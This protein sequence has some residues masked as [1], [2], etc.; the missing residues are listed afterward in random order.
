MALLVPLVSAPSQWFS[1]LLDNQMCQ[2]NVYDK[3][4]PY[5]MM[6]SGT[7]LYLDLY[8]NNELIIGGVVCQ[9]NNRIVRQAYLG[10][11]GDL[12]FCDNAGRG[13]D[14]VWEGLGVDYSLIYLTQEELDGA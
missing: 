9:C 12:F 6:S 11:L 13:R 5:F 10:F 4:S 8:V 1:V 3:T 14:P 7:A 2:I